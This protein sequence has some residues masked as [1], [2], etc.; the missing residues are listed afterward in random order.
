M[1]KRDG[2]GPMS[3]GAMTGRGMGP[4]TENTV[5]NSVGLGMGA[6]L[7]LACR[8]GY[9]GGSKKRLWKMF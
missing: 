2:S 8:R 3:A 6:G 4:C 5:K 9:G 7:G 1:P